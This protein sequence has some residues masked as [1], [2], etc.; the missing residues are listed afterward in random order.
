MLHQ[1]IKDFPDR[2][3]TVNFLYNLSVGVL[4]EYYT[5]KEINS[6]LVTILTD[7]GLIYRANS[8]SK[9]FYLGP[10]V[11]GLLTDSVN[12]NPDTEKFLIIENNFRVFAYTKSRLHIALLSYF[13]QLTYQLPNLVIGCI[14]RSSIVK[15]YKNGL[16]AN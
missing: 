12:M 14:T 11:V 16:R 13:M 15:A 6:S 10:S 7:I 2:S 8:N 4:N 5:C 1:I 3:N 9:R